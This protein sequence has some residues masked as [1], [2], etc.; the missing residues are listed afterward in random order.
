MNDLRLSKQPVS[1]EED[2][3]AEDPLKCRDQSP[4]FFATLVHSECLKHLRCGSEPNGLALLLNRESRQ[5][6]WHDAVLAEGHDIFGMT[7]DLENELPV[8]ALVEKLPLRKAS[9]WKPAKDERTRAE[10]QR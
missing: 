4:V 5:E 7:G 8:P 10:T 1:P 2:R 3:R 9:H 6:D